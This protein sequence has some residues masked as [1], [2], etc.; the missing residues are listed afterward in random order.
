M[1]VL[2]IAATVAALLFLALTVIKSMHMFQL[3]SY[4]TP[5]HISWLRKH[6][7]SFLPGL[8]GAAVA[9][10][11]LLPMLTDV[12]ALAITLAVYAVLAATQIPRKAKKPLV[13]TKRV[14]RMLVTIVLL[15]MVCTVCCLMNFSRGSFLITLVC[16][17]VISPLLVLIANTVNKPLEKAINQYYIRDARK[18]LKSNKDLLTLGVTGS[19]GK[20]SVKYILHTLLQAEYD[21][22]KTPESYNTPMGVIKTVRGMLR[23]TH[24]I[25]VC[26][27]GAR[28]VGD[29]KELCDIVEPKMGII[30]SVGPQHL[31]TFHSIENVRKTKFELADALPADGTI[32]LNLEDANIRAQLPYAGKRVVSYGLSDQCD[33]YATD[34]SASSKGTT[35]TAHTPDGRIETYV[36]KM[37]GAHNVINIIGAIAVCC[38][39]GIPLE[40]LKMQIRKLESVPHRLQLIRRNGITIID[41]A[42]NSN[43]TGS[44]AAIDALALFDGYKVLVTPGMVELG[45]K[46]DELNYAFGAYAAGVCDYVALVGKKQTQSIY[47]GLLSAGYPEERIYVSDDLQ[48]ALSNVYAVDAGNKEKIILL[49]NDLPDNF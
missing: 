2:Y 25:F 30:T 33:Y 7:G 13:Y 48:D 1:I 29:I 40:K 46:Q 35:F 5:T 18:I 42:Y 38:E 12:I 16:V 44:R 49:E 6:M 4:K 14:N 32:F 17:S 11:M 20:T 10:L 9:A 47:D 34:I 27:M 43:P 39:L 8:V 19:Y 21:V 45:E 3:N 28:H 31:E 24:Q 15:I 36:A 22:L 26:E 41:D 23:A 37:I